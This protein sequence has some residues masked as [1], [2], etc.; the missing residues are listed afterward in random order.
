MKCATLL[1]FLIFALQQARN[2]V[3][4][5]QDRNEVQDESRFYGDAR[6]CVQSAHPFEKDI[7][8]AKVTNAE[9]AKDAMTRYC[10]SVLQSITEEFAN[11][12]LQYTRDVRRD[13][14]MPAAEIVQ[15]DPCKFRG[16]KYKK[17]KQFKIAGEV[18]Q[19][20]A[21]RF[22]RIR[23]RN[24]LDEKNDRKKQKQECK[25]ALQVIIK[26]DPCNT[27]STQAM[28][29]LKDELKSGDTKVPQK[30]DE[31]PG[32]LVQLVS[33]EKICGETLEGISDPTTR[34]TATERFADAL[35]AFLFGR[36]GVAVT[37]FG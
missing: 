24:L 27:F 20:E 11:A 14:T 2:S 26:E 25:A 30:K 29:D 37:F 10:K 5:S 33:R 7:I 8:I 1:L 3:A 9:Q 13:I 21:D 16:L 28:K 22:V 36:P 4:G 12:L 18:P 35:Y 23:C 32:F 31:W 19:K 34:E 15:R 6:L 17:V